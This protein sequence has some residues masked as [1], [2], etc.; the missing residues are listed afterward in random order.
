MVSATF[1]VLSLHLGYAGKM[2]CTDIGIS[3]GA[4]QFGAAGARYFFLPE[5][6]MQACR[7]VYMYTF[8]GSS[9]YL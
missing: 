4:K 7:Y 1:C 5:Y 8:K 9:R 2:I 6:V 3:F